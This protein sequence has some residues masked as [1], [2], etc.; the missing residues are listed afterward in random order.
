[1]RGPSDSSTEPNP[2]Q[3]WSRPYAAMTEDGCKIGVI[4]KVNAPSQDGLLFINYAVIH[5]NLFREFVG[6]RYKDSSRNLTYGRPIGKSVDSRIV[7][8]QTEI[9]VSNPATDHL[10]DRV[11]KL[12]NAEMLIREYIAV[13]KPA[14]WPSN[15]P[16]IISSGSV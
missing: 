14:G 15:W 12:L 16:P 5:D 7:N 3:T 4:P 13:H 1:M 8:G 2:D 10:L 6:F 9:N 11:K